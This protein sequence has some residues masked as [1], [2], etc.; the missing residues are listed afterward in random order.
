M[1][2]LL[3]NYPLKALDDSRTALAKGLASFFKKMEFV[4]P[5]SNEPFQL[6][7]AYTRWAQFR[8]R[9]MS[10][11]GILPAAACLPDRPVYSA[12]SFTPRV[13]EETWS[14]GDPTELADDGVSLRY[15]WGDGGGDGY[16]LVEIAQLSV[17]FVVLLRGK[18]IAQC[19]AMTKTTEETFVEDATELPDKSWLNPKIDVPD[20]DEQPVRYGRVVEIPRYYNRKARFTLVAQQILDNEAAAMENRWTAQFEMLGEMQVCVRRR[21]RAM[22]PRV[23]LFVNDERVSR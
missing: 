15:P 6:R 23:E 4:L 14:G 9:A 2:T 19:E 7:A 10:E 17:P 22:R 13:L 8:D 12:A 18:S 3:Q 5:R 16:V 21:L 11:G 20:A 1:T